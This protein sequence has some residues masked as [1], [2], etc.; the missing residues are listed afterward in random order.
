MSI[1]LSSAEADR[2]DALVERIAA[3]AVGTFDLVN[4]YLGVRLGLFGALAGGPASSFELAGRTGLHER[5][6]REWLEQGAVAGILDLDRAG[7]EPADRWFSLPAGHAEVLLDVESLN[8]AAPTALSLMGAIQVALRPLLDVFQTGAGFPFDVSGDDMRNGEAASNRPTYLK[9]LGQSWLP[10]MA[11]LHAR[12]LA[13]PAA[14]IVDIGMGYGW[15]SIAM[16][17]AY[18]KVTVDGL[19]LDPVSVREAIRNAAEAGVADRVRFAHRTAADPALAGRYDLVTAFECLHD[20]SQPVAVLA[21]MRRLLT[22][23]GTVLI[24]D[25]RA[26]EALAAPGD[27]IQRT[28]YGWSV[29]HCLASAMD[30]P[31]ASGTGTVFRPAILRRYAQE[32]GFRTV[33]IVPIKHETWRFYRLWP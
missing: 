10:T 17:K 26:D 20:M 2:R 14:R 3:D 19:D 21:A 31:N 33:E 4:V 27:D 15:S 5:Y 12:L 24:G 6:V 13:D 8:Y 23:G 29:L 25:A 9:L 16:A 28:F 30:G 7:A 1:E 22:D 11:D 32:A 18:P